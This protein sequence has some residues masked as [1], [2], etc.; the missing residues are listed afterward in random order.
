MLSRFG[1][2]NPS[3][4]YVS[5]CTNSFRTGH[6]ESGSIVFGNDEYGCLESTLASII[7]DREATSA[8]LGVEPSH[9]ALREP[10]LQVLNLLRSM[11]YQ[12]KIP[13]TLDGPPMHNAYKAKLW[14]IHEKVRP[15]YFT[16]EVDNVCSEKCALI[17]INCSLAFRLG[18]V[19][20]HKKDM[21][22]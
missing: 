7:L 8:S 6:Y 5:Q 1:N 11:N 9:G 4:R 19:R 15:T 16:V 2:S 20:I 3:P 10:I 22:Q 12:A 21:E 17:Y 13:D 14:K 18:K